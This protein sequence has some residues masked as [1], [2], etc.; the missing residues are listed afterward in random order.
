M[1]S[2]FEVRAA[3]VAEAAILHRLLVLAF[4]QYEGK[5]DPP[6]GAHGETV[7]SIAGKLSE[8][9]AF[10]CRHGDVAV[11]CIFH[12]PKDDYLYIGRLS[13]VPDYRKRGVGDLLL[14][15]AEQHATALGLPSVRLGVRLVLEALRTYYARRGYVSI[16]LHSHP[17]YTRPTFVE[18]EKRLT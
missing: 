13:V 10:I 15:A 4:S 12:A 3:R 9:G 1:T 2:P 18:M 8:G 6:S 14:S 11:G 7:E 5:L 17:G 16:G